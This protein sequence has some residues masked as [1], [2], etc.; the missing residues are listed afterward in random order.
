VTHFL[1]FNKALWALDKILTEK[2]D[3]LLVIEFN[4][5]LKRLFNNNV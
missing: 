5:T 4:G 3:L 1:S 2:L